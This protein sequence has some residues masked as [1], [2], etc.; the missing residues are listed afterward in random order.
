M[1]VKG[2]REL[3]SFIVE[4]GMK[5]FEVSAKEDKLGNQRK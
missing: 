1:Q 2:T 5:G 3:M 4:K